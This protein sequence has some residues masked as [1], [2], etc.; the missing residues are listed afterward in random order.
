MRYCGGFDGSFTVVMLLCIGVWWFRTCL[1]ICFGGRLVWCSVSRWWWRLSYSA[2]GLTPVS[3][4]G[5][6]SVLFFSF[7]AFFRF[8]LVYEWWWW[9][10]APESFPV[11]FSVPGLHS[12]IRAVGGGT[13]CCFMFWVVKECLTCLTVGVVRPRIYVLMVTVWWWWRIWVSL[14]EYPVLVFVFSAVE[15]EEQVDF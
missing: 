11:L 15:G 5:E 13:W 6:V 12:N 9:W 2:R 3:F 7:A 4:S 1:A 10:S 14:Q 8:A